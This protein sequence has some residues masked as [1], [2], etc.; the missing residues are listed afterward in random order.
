L[1]E[2]GEEH[3]PEMGME[4]LATELLENKFPFQT[5]FQQ[6]SA[7]LD[8]PNPAFIERIQFKSSFEF[9]SQ[10]NKY[11][12]H[13]ENNSFK[14]VEL[15]VAG[16]IVPVPFIV[17]KFK[18]WHRMPIL[19]RIPEVVKEILQFIRNKANRK[20]TGR[21]KSQVW[22]AIPRMFN[23]RSAFDVYK[24]FYSWI[25]KRDLFRMMP[26][27]TIEYA[28]VFPLIYC[29]IRLEGVQTYD[30]IK[31][32]LVDEMQDY[33]PIQYAVLSRV[34]KCKK[35][36]LG[37]VNQ[38]VNPYSA[39]SAEG[40]EQIFPQGD[41]VKLLRSYRSTWEISNFALSIIP[42]P[43]L[44]AMERHGEHPVTLGFNTSAE[45]IDGI[46]KLI[47]QYGES[48]NQS[49]GIICKTHQQAKSLYQILKASNVHLLTADSTSFANGIIITTVHLAKGLEFDEVI[50]PFISESNYNTDVDKRMLYIACTRA[51]H[52]LTL[53][54]HGP[55]T[56]F[57][58][59]YRN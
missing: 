46:K 4:E 7:L 45:E 2:L 49:V 55:K 39:S 13:I 22:E 19:K 42:N 16:V 33:T 18:A 5:F 48:A 21:E 53:T 40:I 52:R 10:L 24:D 59:D 41:V 34:F 35:T 28:D 51:M 23:V 26:D 12:I 56:S 54:H 27:N 43:N 1:P 31:H 9:L 38:T 15:K 47:G 14:H 6:V 57:I 11:F 37:D 17:E 44:I 32:L 36:I 3:I 58:E 29:K 8:N 25:G 30:H 20:L 50:V